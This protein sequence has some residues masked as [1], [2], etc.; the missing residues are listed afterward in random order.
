MPEKGIALLRKKI[1]SI[2]AVLL[3]AVARRF[4]LMPEF[5]SL[6]RENGLPLRQP[7]REKELISKRVAFGKKLGVEGRFV[8][9]LFRAL[10]LESLRIQRKQIRKGK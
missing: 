9:K 5:A 3:K 4:S 7:G 8:K 10:I 6:K 2:D 1:D